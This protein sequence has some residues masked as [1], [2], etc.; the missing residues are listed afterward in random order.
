MRYLTLMLII[1]AL[2]VSACSKS[3]PATATQTFGQLADAGRSVFASRC[4]QCHGDN[5]Q[6]LNAPA[7]IGSNANLGKYNTAQGLLDY[8][9]VTMPFNAPGS[10]S[11]QEY[12]NVLGFLLVQNNYVSASTAFDSNQLKN[13][14]LK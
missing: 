1:V 6:G 13:I 8:I 9:D 3:P 14:L 10:L 5:G 11:S 12:S 7:V 2:V 4:A